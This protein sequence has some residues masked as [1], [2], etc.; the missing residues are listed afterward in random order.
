MADD[1]KR[2]KAPPVSAPE[3]DPDAPP[4]AEE[5]VESERLRR[6]L[7]DPKS[8]HEDVLLAR[9]LGSAM[10][11]K[12]LDDDEHRALLDRAL[13]A[14][15]DVDPDA[16]ATPEEIAESERLAEEL[17]D[18]GSK[19]PDVLL[20]RS[21]RNAVAPRP[22]EAATHRKIL[23]RALGEVRARRTQTLWIATAFAAAAAIALWLLPIG[24]PS[25]DDGGIGP[26]VTA[27]LVRVHAVDDLFAEPFP[28][29]QLTSARIDR[30]ASARGRDLRSN[31]FAKWG[32]H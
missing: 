12:E 23:D 21:L 9:A 3:V 15:A 16:P 32:V 20:A 19:H 6:E 7:E 13:S 28:Q 17:E 26:D 5:I 4:S 1:D 22:I 25:D 10:H 2:K 24:K 30:I 11:P 14:V 27:G 31:H 8:T 29:G 18:P